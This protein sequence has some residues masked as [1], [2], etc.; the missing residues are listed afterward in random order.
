MDNDF[1]FR[2]NELSIE[3]K[4]IVKYNK[5]KVTNKLMFSPCYIRY[6]ARLILTLLLS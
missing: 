3:K 1:V 4:S 6:R 5:Y 2:I